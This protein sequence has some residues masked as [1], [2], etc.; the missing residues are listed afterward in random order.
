VRSIR[1]TQPACASEH[2]RRLR[3]VSRRGLAWALVALVAIAAVGALQTSA[4]RSGV[5]ALGATPAA[6]GYTEVAVT[7]EPTAKPAGGRKLDVAFVI[8]IH[9]VD[10][11]GGYR[12][13]LVTKDAKPV[14]TAPA[15]TVDLEAGQRGAVEVR[16]TVRCDAGVKRAWVG[17][18]VDP[19]PAASVG[20]WFDCPEAAS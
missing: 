13:A 15:G 16:A 12:W 5:D 8:M 2:D 11:G 4:G 10:D 18:Q 17:A 6:A 9:D 3:R 14:G 20:S 7:N 1:R 19:E